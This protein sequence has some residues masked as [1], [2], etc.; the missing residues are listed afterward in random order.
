MNAVSKLP[1]KDRDQAVE[2]FSLLVKLLDDSVKIH[3]P[4]P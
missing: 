4:L 3:D 1:F 2:T